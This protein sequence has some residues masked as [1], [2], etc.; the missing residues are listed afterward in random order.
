MN[1]III[2]IIIISTTTTTT[3]T[4]TTHTKA[5]IHRSRNFEVVVMRRGLLRLA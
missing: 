3:T 5:N 2:I 1:I 4:T